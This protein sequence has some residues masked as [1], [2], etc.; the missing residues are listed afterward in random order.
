[1][2]SRIVLTDLIAAVDR[3]VGLKA[4]ATELIN[5]FSAKLSA[6]V[7]EAL[8]ADDAADAGTVDAV[9]AAIANV[10][11]QATTASDALAAALANHSA[12]PP[13]P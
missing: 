12:P 11:T 9:N 6:A 7:A 2:P 1:M 3:S 8:A 4:S 10:T 5:G 13:T